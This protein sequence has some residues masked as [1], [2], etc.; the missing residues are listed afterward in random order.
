[1]TDDPNKFISPEFLV[2]VDDVQAGSIRA[3]DEEREKDRAWLAEQRATTAQLNSSELLR[4]LVGDL[5]PEEAQARLDAELDLL[6]QEAQDA[7]KAKEPVDD[8]LP[9]DH[10]PVPLITVE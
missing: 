7:A 5:D 9:S 8:Q 4:A 2:L 10:F 1:V 3:M 6:D